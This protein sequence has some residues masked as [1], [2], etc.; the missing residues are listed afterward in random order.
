MH[1][2]LGTGARG[3]GRSNSP[4]KE[5]SVSYEKDSQPGTL[6]RSQT[7]RVPEQ[8]GR[9]KH[10][11]E[12]GVKRSAIDFWRWFKLNLTMWLMY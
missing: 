3:L 6:V 1:D 9:N 11:S 8:L 5:A 10:A 12:T 4:C 7:S 2:G